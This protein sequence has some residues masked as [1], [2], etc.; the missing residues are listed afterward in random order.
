MIDD[1]L[2]TLRPYL[3]YFGDRVWIQALVIMVLSLLIAWIFNRF[4]ISSLKN[5]AS[6]TQIGLDNQLIELLHG[7]IYT[8][9]ILI[10]FAL[11][12]NLLKLGDVFE[13]VVFSSLQTIAY[14][15]WTVFLLRNTKI[16][17]RHIA[18]DERH[19]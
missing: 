7:P 13:F 15:V 6:K 19:A 11:A 17:L 2:N 1:L 16:V 14:F 3:G 18:Q 9:V 10:G 12:T 5:L 8:S 4:V